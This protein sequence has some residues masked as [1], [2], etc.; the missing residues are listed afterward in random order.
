M[1]A[2]SDRDFLLEYLAAC[3]ILMNHLGRSCEEFV[4]WMSGEFGFV[5]LPDRLCTGSSIM[6]Q[7]KNPGA[8]RN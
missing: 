3:S 5:T 1:D 7:K 8:W 4:I 6:P 2:V